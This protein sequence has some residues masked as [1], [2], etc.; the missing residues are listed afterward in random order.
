MSPGKG[1]GREQA[2]ILATSDTHGRDLRS[3]QHVFICDTRI[4]VRHVMLDW[5]PY[6][7]RGTAVSE[8]ALRNHLARVLDENCNKAPEF[9]WA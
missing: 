6:E 7:H 4:G 2:K 9:N 1:G 5:L 8:H 3:M